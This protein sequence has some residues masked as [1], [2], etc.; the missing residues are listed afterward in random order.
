MNQS[1][2]RIRLMRADDFEAVVRID[3]K[4]LKASRPEYYK[5][6]FEKLFDSR[7]YL[8]VSLVAEA[9]DGT[10]EGFVMGELY[11]GQ[12]GIF[13]EAATLDSIGVDPDAQHKGVGRQLIDEFVDHLRRV[14]VRKITTL[15]DWNDSSLI[16][17][18]SENQFSPSRTI[19]LERVL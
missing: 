10:V 3:A 17:F 18:F 9:A 16:R 19:N 1:H 4:I 8:P 12:Y 15:V 14:G 2:A 6:K 11:M 5:T 7:D 13:Q